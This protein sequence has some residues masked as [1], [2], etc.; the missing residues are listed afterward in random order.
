MLSTLYSLWTGRLSMIISGY[1]S[2]KIS[3]AEMKTS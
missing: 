1:A 2:V 3:L